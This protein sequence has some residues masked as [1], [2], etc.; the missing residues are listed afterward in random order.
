MP[1]VLAPGR[2]VHLIRASSTECHPALL[3]FARD[4]THA[5]LR[6]MTDDAVL[7]AVERGTGQQSVAQRE[8]HWH[9]LETCSATWPVVAES[10]RR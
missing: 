4:P 6:D 8:A 5:N 3:L 1:F 10:V 7:R 2:I 9:E